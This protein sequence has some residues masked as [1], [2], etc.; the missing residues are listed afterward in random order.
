MEKAQV[1][2]QTNQ[3]LHLRPAAKLVKCARLFR[4]KISLCH[5]CKEADACSIID[6]LS[7]GAGKGAAI[8]VRAEGADARQAIRSI[9]ELFNDGAGI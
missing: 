5:G 2:I 3:G 8:K 1:T 4:S 7:L 9:T 6:V